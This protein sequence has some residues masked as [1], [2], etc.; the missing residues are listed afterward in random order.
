MTVRVPCGRAH[1][2]LLSVAI[3]TI[4]STSVSA[5]G[6]GLTHTVSRNG[7]LVE[8]PRIDRLDRV[9]PDNNCYSVIQP[10]P[11][12]ST[13][14]S[15]VNE[16]DPQAV[17]A[18]VVANWVDT[19]QMDAVAFY[20]TPDC[21]EDSKALIVRWFSN[22][23]LPQMVY[24]AAGYAGNRVPRRL[25]AYKPIVIPPGPAPEED[26]KL[27]SADFESAVLLNPGLLKPGSVFAP[28]TS[29]RPSATYCS[30]LVRYTAFGERE[31]RALGGIAKGYFQN[32][33]DSNAI[34]AE[35]DSASWSKLE[36]EFGN[37]L[38]QLLT[39]VT[40]SEDQLRS[41]R[42][43]Y[44]PGRFGCN[45]LSKQ[46]YIDPR[47]PLKPAAIEEEDEVV[48]LDEVIIDS[49][50]VNAGQGNAEE[51]IIQ[52][53]QIT[54]SILE[55]DDLGTT[56]TTGQGLTGQTISDLS[57]RE[58]FPIS[59]S[60]QSQFSEGQGAVVAGG[61]RK[62]RAQRAQEVQR[63][64][65]GR[66]DTVPEAIP[67]ENQSADEMDIEVGPTKVQ[68]TEGSEG[69]RVRPVGN[70]NSPENA[71]YQDLVASRQNDPVYGPIDRIAALQGQNWD[72]R[73]LNSL[74]RED[75]GSLETLRNLV[76]G[77]GQKF[78]ALN[79]AAAFSGGVPVGR[80]ENYQRQGVR[81]PTPRY[82]Q[83]QGNNIDIPALQNVQN[84]VNAASQQPSEFLRGLNEL[85]LEYG[86]REPP[87]PELRTGNNILPN[88]GQ[89]PA[90]K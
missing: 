1:L 64:R 87:I 70:E 11:I 74:S 79:L 6:F 63:R 8:V 30:G 3:L 39:G 31:I 18:A 72:G 62:L 17:K 50:Q 32:N 24:L 10:E 81:I 36:E 60:S 52:E 89:P 27:A 21:R 44:M 29:R 84:D 25:V 51:K 37:Q 82:L 57:S 15:H 26:Y 83:A 34:P 33:P 90:G 69:I 28:S 14:G 73:G 5:F 59:A 86:G 2:T 9:S 22:M 47:A 40:S 42:N 61:R 16:G 71:A 55:A 49:D 38:N 45:A 43:I 12:R 53:K 19:A 78:S 67:Q 23:A 4:F 13:D 46:A 20:T 66:T 41:A 48:Q 75:S 85:W 65:Q 54:E 68:L 35:L 58:R 76:S 80:D 56:A 77:L 7:I 88:S